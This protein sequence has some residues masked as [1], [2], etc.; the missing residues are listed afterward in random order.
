MVILW[1]I[2][3][4][5]GCTLFAVADETP[6]PDH[7]RSRGVHHLHRLEHAGD[8]RIIPAHAGC[9][10]LTGAGVAS[11]SDHPRSRGVHSREGTVVPRLS[12]SSPLTRGAHL[13]EVSGRPAS[14]I[15]PAH[16]GC[17][18]AVSWMRWLRWDHPRS[19]GVHADAGLEPRRHYGSSPLTR[20]AREVAPVAV[21]ELGSSPLTRGARHTGRIGHA[22][23]RII[24]AHAGCT[25]PTS[26]PPTRAPDHPRS[27]GVHVYPWLGLIRAVGS[28][29]LTR[30]ARG[31]VA[32]L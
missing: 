21:P 5:A 25:T 8:L 24:P 3:A 32:Y 29:P 26:G 20:G 13:L 7:P 27:R 17:T 1:I 14:R 6:A 18:V 9:T 10:V 2:P 11:A 19:R 15:I 4:H 22:Q 28:S 30:G 23:A 12:G 16:A 31:G